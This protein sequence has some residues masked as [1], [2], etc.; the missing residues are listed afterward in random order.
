MSLWWRIRHIYRWR[1]LAT[2]AGS[3]R[4]ACEAIHD[5]LHRYTDS[6]CD[7][8]MDRENES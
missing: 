2:V 5:R 1:A 7:M 6:G 4:R 3:V 8:C